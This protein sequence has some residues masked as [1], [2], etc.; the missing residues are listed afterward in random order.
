MDIGYSAREFAKKI[1]FRSKAL[2]WV[3]KP[4]Y[5]Y[6]LKPAQLAFLVDAIDRTRHLG[7]NIVEVGVARGMTTVFLNQHMREA[8]DARQYI[9]VDT[10]SGFTQ[11]AVAYERERRGKDDRG[12]AGFAYNDASVFRKNIESNGFSVSI[13]Q[14]DCG[15]LDKADIGNV[16]VALLDVD[17][18]LPTM[19]AIGTIYDQ[20][21]TGGVMMVDD[22]AMGTNY[23]GAAVAYFEFCLERGLPPLVIA[24]KAGMLVK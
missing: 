21:Q 5:R 14:K 13:I 7:G 16:S 8:G 1:A 19:R 4:T 10:F 12:L 15:L 22:V 11:E 17:L 2:N 24:G 6:N 23:D 9:C 3:S 20:L 18:Y